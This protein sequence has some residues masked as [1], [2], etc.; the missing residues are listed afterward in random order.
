MFDKFR[1]S[2]MAAFNSFRMSMR[3]YVV[4]EYCKDESIPIRRVWYDDDKKI[5]IPCDKGYCHFTRGSKDLF[6]AAKRADSMR[7]VRKKTK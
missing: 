5:W 1:R 3:D 7:P 4:K 6:E 2:V